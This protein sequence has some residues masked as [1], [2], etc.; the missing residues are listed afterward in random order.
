MK[1]TD[2]IVTPVA[3]PVKPA[4]TASKM[5]I[6]ARVMP[7]VLVEVLTDE[8]ITGIGESPS[9]LG[10]DL[11][12]EF[13]RS[14]KEFM[15]GEDPSQI[16]VL[17]KKLYARYNLTHLHVH[18]GNWA[19]NGI[20]LALWDIA[21]KRAGMPLYQLWGGAYRKKNRLLRHC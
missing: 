19:L 13:V 11:T 20:E 21:G 18:L 15:V 5:R 9:V 8:G 14:A 16:N 6:G 10:L 3:V 17:M 7:A 12:A 4:E 1:I 2:I